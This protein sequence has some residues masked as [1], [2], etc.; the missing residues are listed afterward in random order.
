MNRIQ[1]LPRFET[2]DHNQAKVGRFTVK[3]ENDETPSNPRTE[4]DNAARIVAVMP[5]R[6]TGGF[7]D[8]KDRDKEISYRGDYDLADLFGEIIGLRA[9]AGQT[10]DPDDYNPGDG[11]GIVWVFFDFCQGNY[12]TG[13]RPSKDAREKLT[14]EEINEYDGFAY[15]TAADIAENWGKGATCRTHWARAANLIRGEIREMGAYVA[16]ESYGYT[17]T[18]TPEDDE[19]EGEE[20]DSCWGYLEPDAPTFYGKRA[21]YVT[22]EALHS[23]WR[24]EKDARAEDKRARQ[25]ARELAAQEAAETADVRQADPAY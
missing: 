12:I 21:G 5:D 24:L 3:I 8:T 14:R 13:T 23:A 25:A 10:V 17:I 6:N 9:I 18:E 4:N 20:V 7:L 11:T 22:E 16:G 1:R 2:I 15:M 19:T